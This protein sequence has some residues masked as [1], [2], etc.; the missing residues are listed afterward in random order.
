VTDRN[1][2]AGP[3]V[4]CYLGRVRLSEV[5]PDLRLGLTAEVEFELAVRH[6]A[7]VVP[8]AAVIREDGRYVCHVLGQEGLV[9]RSI[10]VGQATPDWLE[11]VEG[12]VEGEEV[13]LPRESSAFTQN[14]TEPRYG[15]EKPENHS[16]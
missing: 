8:P 14:G 15:V 2:R 9:R 6:N 7:L 12:L 4:K 5:P 16:L 10:C 1:D 13:L 3:D 11:V